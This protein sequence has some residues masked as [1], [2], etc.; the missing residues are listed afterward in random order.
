[1][2]SSTFSFYSFFCFPLSSGTCRCGSS[3]R[4]SA[5]FSSSYGIAS[6]SGAFVFESFSKYSAVVMAC[7]FLERISFFLVALKAA[8][9]LSALARGLVDLARMRSAASR[10]NSVTPCSLVPSWNLGPLSS[11]VSSFGGFV[12]GS[13]SGTPMSALS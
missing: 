11:T 9:M 10:V 12:S 1:M 5:F 6:G 8:A 2:R 13:G 7:R 3:G 4:S